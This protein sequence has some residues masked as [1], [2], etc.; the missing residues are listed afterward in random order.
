MT[1]IIPE[2]DI[3]SAFNTELVD[4]FP[5]YA[6]AG[7]IAMQNVDFDPPTS[8]PWLRGT[9][10]PAEPDI[11]TLGMPPFMQYQGIYQVD[12]FT[13]QNI[14]PY[15]P[16]TIAAEVVAAFTSGLPGRMLVFNGLEIRIVKA[17][18]G[19]ATPEDTGWYHIPVNIAYRCHSND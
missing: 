19:Q 13:K 15:A 17:W 14:G 4:A 1:T 5:A 12:V 6:S 10:L 18:L 8:D 11:A 16:S 7:R 9:L 2:R 3:Q